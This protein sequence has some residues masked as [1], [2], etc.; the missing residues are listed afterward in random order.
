M[1]TVSSLQYS[2]RTMTKYGDVASPTAADTPTAQGSGSCSSTAMGQHC[3]SVILDT[4]QPGAPPQ[5]L[6]AYDS[7][8]YVP[9][10]AQVPT[11]TVGRAP[12]DLS[13][14][15][16]LRIQGRPN[17]TRVPSHCPDQRSRL[18]R[19]RPS[20]RRELAHEQHQPPLRSGKYNRAVDGKQFAMEGAADA[21]ARA[22]SVTCAR[23]LG[24]RHF[25][26]AARG[27]LR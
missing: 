18:S 4:V 7:Y 15:S 10:T 19:W 9:V 16:Q 20:L 17:G 25:R 3:S 27:P 2:S 12:P 8:M 5:E 23:P 21:G 22:P 13:L 26:S 24:S 6:A 1:Q 11:R 14:L